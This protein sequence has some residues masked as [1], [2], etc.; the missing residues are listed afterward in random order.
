MP[1]PSSSLIGEHPLMQKIEAMA[2]RVAATDAT[3]LIMGESGTGKELVARAIH[4]LG[5]RSARPFVPVNCAALPEDLLE[6]ELFGHVR[7][8]FTGALS[9]RVGMFQLAD[10]G[11]ILLDEV[12]E[13]PFPLQA[14][15]LRV[16]QNR[17]VRPVGSDQSLSVN[18][19]V[20]AATNKDLQQEVEKSAFREDLFYRLQV[21]PIHLPPLRARRSD[22]PMLVQFFLEKNN[23][24]YTRE[25][26]IA[27]ETLIYLWEYDWP[28]NVRELENLLERLVVLNETNILTPEDLPSYVRSFIA[29]K[30]L[31][32]PQIS[33][34]DVD[35]RQV[36]DQ[37]ES[38]LIDEALR[39]TNGNKSAA[40]QML[41]LKRTTLVAKLR[42]KKQSSSSDEGETNNTNLKEVYSS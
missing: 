13:M 35:L 39:R 5:P 36:L 3:I 2:R 24:K 16:L 18:V 42:K 19:R 12:G 21:I 10:G 14:K 32:H 29:E 7:G 4:N 30:K 20:I 11:S 41:G 1:F 6:S 40:A 37:F 34:G 38:R 26:K 33:D 9:S 23:R 8:A 31:P 27:E 17:E 25:V 15:L 28:G 22:I